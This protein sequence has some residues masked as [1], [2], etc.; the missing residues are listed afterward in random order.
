MRFDRTRIF[1]SLIVVALAL[2]L[3][4]CGSGGS[5]TPNTSGTA[6]VRF[7]NGSPD[8]GAFDVLV[9]GKVVVSN[10]AY[11]QITSYQNLTVGT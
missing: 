10:V 4:S 9:N 3:A 1:A 6:M 5:T 2:S 7:I 11:G 8:A